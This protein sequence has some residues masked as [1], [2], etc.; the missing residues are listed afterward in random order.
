VIVRSST[1]SSFVFRFFALRAK[2][3]K[4]DEMR[5]TRAI[6]AGESTGKEEQ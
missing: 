1:L 5:S 3:R 4:T 2:K 6:T